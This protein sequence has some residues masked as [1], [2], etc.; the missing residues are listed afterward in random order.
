MKPED[1]KKGSGNL[2]RGQIP[3]NPSPAPSATADSSHPVMSSFPTLFPSQCFDAKALGAG[4]EPCLQTP[5]LLQADSSLS[6]PARAHTYTSS[7]RTPWQPTWGA[8]YSTDKTSLFPWN[9]W[10]AERAI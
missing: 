10:P 2:G 8:I 9:V 6:V 3:P 7:T 4:A 1:S 5:N